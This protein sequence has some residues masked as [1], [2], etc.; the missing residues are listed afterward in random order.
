M[1]LCFIQSIK[2]VVYVNLIKLF[3]FPAFHLYK[4]NYL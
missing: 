1:G 4:K 2:C 3:D